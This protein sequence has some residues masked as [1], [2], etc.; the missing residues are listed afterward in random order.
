MGQPENLIMLGN[1]IAVAIVS[2]LILFYFEKRYFPSAASKYFATTLVFIAVTAVLDTVTGYFI[3]L[4]PKIPLWIG[5]A[6]NSLHFISNILTTT[7]MAMIFFA[8]I[9]EHVHDDFCMKRAKIVLSLIFI[10]YFI[11]VIANLKTGIFFYFDEGF[12]TRGVLNTLGYGFVGLQMIFVI[13]CFFKHRDFTTRA[14]KRVLIQCFPIA[15]VCIIV[16]LLFPDVLLNSLIMSL[17]ALVTYLNFQS[18]QPGVHMLT[19]INDRH[20][21]FKYIETSFASKKLFRTYVIKIKNFDTFNQKYGHKVGDELLYLFAFAL[22]KVIKGASVFHMD[23]LRFALV[24]PDNVN[25][26][27]HEAY[28]RICT[29]FDRGIEYGNERFKLD[30]TLVEHPIMTAEVDATAF[31]EALEYGIDVA[32]DIGEKYFIFTREFSEAHQRRKYLVK[33]LEKIDRE[34][35]YEVWYQPTR[36]MSNGIYCS[37]E[38][39]IRLRE[40]DGSIVSP[41]EFISIAEQTGMINPLTWFVIEESCRA[42]SENPELK[43]VNVSINMPMTQMFDQGFTERLNA[44]TAEYGVRHHQI[45]LEITERVV[46]D[47]FNRIKGIM[48]N[49]AKQGYRFFLDDFGMGYSNFNCLLRLPFTTVKLDRTLTSTVLSNTNEQNI[50]YM[51]TEL[52]HKMDLKVVAE[53]AE[54][55]EQIN[56]LKE[57]GIDRIQGYYYAKPMDL[58]KIIAFFTKNPLTSYM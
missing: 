39:L 16:Q 7:F 1:Y 53:G 42:I 56:V 54:T 4:G 55:E 9:L 34:H 47:D 41:G 57:Y 49:I 3:P 27:P 2:I 17:I 36:C 22:E 48:E 46:M 23:N 28:D 15:I 26:S 51:L 37:M 8:K 6:V 12:Y 30:Y 24:I 33:R 11:L 20:R 32:E 40:P 44:I 58:Q 21:F 29:F 14:M 25:V 10:A 13:I 31:Y 19:D 45:C 52:F 43:F 50:V 38:A 18:Y 35:G 5:Y